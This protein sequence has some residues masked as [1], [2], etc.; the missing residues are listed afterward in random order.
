MAHMHP[1]VLPPEIKRDP[2]RA[3]ERKFYAECEEQL[4]NDYHVFY[5]SPWL[6]TTF[7]G[8]E[9]DGEADFTIAH[10]EQG[11]LIVEVKGGRVEVA[12]DTLDWLSTDRHDITRRIK[13]PVA[14]ARAGKHHL[15]EGLKARPD[16]S[17]RFIR[18][19]HAA[20]LP[21]T[22]PIKRDI[23][24]DM[25][26]SI[27][28]F[29]PDMQ[30]LPAW[31]S[32]RM[33]NHA[34][35]ADGDDESRVSPLGPD[36]LQA[37]E[38]LLSKGFRFGYDLRTYLHDDLVVLES[39]SPQQFWTIQ[40]LEANRRLAVPGAAGTGKTVIATKLAA[41]AAASGKRALLVCYNAP[42]AQFLESRIGSKKNLK[43]S[44]YAGFCRDLNG[45]ELLDD[46]LLAEQLISNLS[47]KENERFDVIIID[48]GQDFRDDWLQALELALR[49]ERNSTF[50]VFYD[51]NQQVR[52]QSKAYIGEMNASKIPLSLN[53]RNTQKVFS[54]LQKF[55]SGSN[56]SAIGPEGMDVVWKSASDR[57]DAR[58]VLREQLGSLITASRIKPEQIAVLCHTRLVAD[59]LVR[60]G[61]F[62]KFDVTS[63]SDRKKGSVIIDSV[64]RFKGLESDVVILYWPDD[65]LDDTELLYVGF[66]RA[67]ALS[68]VIGSRTAYTTLRIRE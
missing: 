67:R 66:S 21:D 2:L 28:G 41:D 25:P 61:K 26:V 38:G 17:P 49:D 8:E 31:V 62:G 11:L 30:D 7:D 59:E 3:A 22:A 36:G 37:L 6:G 4:P 32:R 63:A 24:P 10:A 42:L 55:Y 9:I 68:V 34:G 20:F 44:T 18:A 35:I 29:A 13:N 52:G 43:V 65:Y 46:E 53:F 5:S 16:W 45:G 39:I 47:E 54:Q 14:Q 27:F 40:L 50:C 58:R 12:G 19:R 64:R 60:V 33:S 1:K 23:A 51:D 57:D 56:V 48:E 15:V